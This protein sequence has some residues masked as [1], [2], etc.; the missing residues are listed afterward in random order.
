MDGKKP[1]DLSNCKPAWSYF[2]KLLQII[3]FHLCTNPRFIVETQIL[4]LKNIIKEYTTY[5]KNRTGTL[6]MFI[7]LKFCQ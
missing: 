2:P 6:E 3:F 1:A 7:N 4:P 5:I